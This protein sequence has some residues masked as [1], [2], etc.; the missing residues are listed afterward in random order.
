MIDITKYGISDRDFFANLDYDSLL[1]HERDIATGSDKVSVTDTGAV[2]IDTGKFTGR[3][4]KDKYIVK[5]SNSEDNIWWKNLKSKNNSDNQAITIEVW[6]DLK[7]I[8]QTGLSEAKNLYITD[9]YCGANHDTRL[10]IRVITETAWMAHFVKNM[11]IEVEEEEKE[12]FV[13]DFVMLNACNSKNP[14]WKKQGLNSETFIA[15]NLEEKIAV[16]GGTSYAGEIKKGFFSIMNYYLPLQNIASMHCS[17][18]EGSKGDTA[19][20]FGLSGTGKTTLSA[21]PKRKLIG[22]D[23]HGWDSDGI[24]N[25]EGGCY[26]KCVN[27]KK[28]KEPDIYNAIRSNALLENVVLIENK[29]DFTNIS[30][31][32][33]TRVSYPIDHIKNIVRPVSKGT[34]P[35][36]II[37]LTADAFGILP[38]VARL[39][40]EQT[41]YYFLSGY[42]AK[43]AGTERGIKE[44]QPTF[45]AC[46]G[47]PFLLLHPIEY[48]LVLEK[49][50]IEHGTKVWL[51]N[52]GWIGGG[53]SKGKRIDITYSRAIISAILEG[54]LD[55]AEYDVLPF[56]NLDIPKKVSGVDSD[57]L[58]PANNWINKDEYNQEAKELAQKFI[59][60]FNT[61]ADEKQCK[62][63][64]KFGPQL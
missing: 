35:K 10:K 2:A 54:E 33:N 63:L 48:A 60:N 11:F 27:L 18:N 45:S 46:F 6:K 51:V 26:A 37:F 44:P 22:D 32:E 58:N 5:Q 57:I 30:K 23:E 47:K 15:F 55:S 12:N 40:E 7:K 3:S 39:S 62:N 29:V 50:I 14:N 9:G 25:L 20:F 17:A 16:I 59:D 41:M 52:T 31:T 53:Y 61:Y 21:D 4:P 56:F 38:P 43:I 1:V 36:N 49:K 8:A 13:P 19:L 28:E 34:H 42:T 24:F 64:V